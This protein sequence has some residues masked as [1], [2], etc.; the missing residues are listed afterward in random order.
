MSHEQAPEVMIY[1]SFFQRQRRSAFDKQMTSVPRGK[2]RYRSCFSGTCVL[3]VHCIHT[4]DLAHGA[5]QSRPRAQSG[6]YYCLLTNNLAHVLNMAT[7]VYCVLRV[8][9]K[10]VLLAH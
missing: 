8:K 7:H 4:N 2:R 3:K 9:V 5:L 6:E 10:C 1:G